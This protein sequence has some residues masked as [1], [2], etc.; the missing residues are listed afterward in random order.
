MSGGALQYVSSYSMKPIKIGLL[1][2]DIVRSSTYRV[3]KRNQKEISG[4]AGFHFFNHH[5][6]MFGIGWRMEVPDSGGDYL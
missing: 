1:G 5:R 6:L 3:L 2:I 4:R